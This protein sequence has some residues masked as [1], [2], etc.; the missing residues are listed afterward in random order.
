MKKPKIFLAADH[1]GFELKE[2]VKK[3]LQ[4]S[5]YD[6]HDEGALKYDAEDDYPD[7]M[8]KAAKK[9]SE[10]KGSK[11]ILFGGSGQ[12]EAIVA[13]K[14]NGIR[15][16][17]Y[18]CNAPEIARLSRAHNDVNILSIGAR[19]VGKEDALKAV[20]LWLETGFSN[21]QRHERRIKKINEME[22]NL[23]K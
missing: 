2:E 13:N 17:V 3:F 6:V 4:G 19:F 8:I 15:A 22:K 10:N 7:F 21:E 11:G 9:V 14:V 5:G 16:A 20:K 18:N 23:L 1:A 12:G